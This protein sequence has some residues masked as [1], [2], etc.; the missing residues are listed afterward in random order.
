[1]TGVFSMRYFAVFPALLLL[2]GCVS[3]GKMPDYACPE[4]G[5]AKDAEIFVLFDPENGP[6]TPE[7]RVL[8]AKMADFDG[9]CRYIKSKSLLETS[10]TVGLRAATGPAGEDLK[11]RKMDFPYFAAVLAPDETILQRQA[12]SM[13]IDFD[14]AGVGQAADTLT[15]KIPVPDKAEAGYYKVVLGFAL[16]PDQLRYNRERK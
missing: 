14:N 12:F 2:A 1:M 7:N 9:G 15:L 4:S 8:E 13:T 3:G 6:K 16:S 5:F 11:G 10:V